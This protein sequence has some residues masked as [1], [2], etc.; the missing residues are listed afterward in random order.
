MMTEVLRVEMAKDKKLRRQLQPAFDAFAQ[1]NHKAVVDYL[2]PLVKQKKGLSPRIFIT[3]LDWLGYAHR[4]LGQF[5]DAVRVSLKALEGHEIYKVDD[6][7]CKAGLLSRIAQC[8]ISEHCSA[9]ELAKVADYCAQADKIYRDLKQTGGRASL[10]NRGTWAGALM[11]QAK[12]VEAE[13]MYTLALAENKDDRTHPTLLAT[14]LSDMGC[15]Y[16]ENLR[17]PNAGW[18]CFVRAYA[19]NS[20]DPLL[21]RNMGAACKGFEQY[22][23]AITFFQRAMDNAESPQQRNSFAHGFEHASNQEYCC[24]SHTNPYAGYYMCSHCTLIAAN[25]TILPCPCGRAWY[26]NNA[27]CQLVDWD[28]HKEVCSFGQ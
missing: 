14:M 11:C 1:H 16:M 9:E 4:E 27:H 20:N 5:D 26:C 2:T 7:V 18:S 28:K 3:A 19:Y 8:M 6:S 22:E 25:E 13:R 10:Y 21:L 15:L 17:M 12:Y 24:G 23:W